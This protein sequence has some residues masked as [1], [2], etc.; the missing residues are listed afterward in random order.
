MARVG[1]APVVALEGVSIRRSGGGDPRRILRDVD[2]RVLAGERWGVLGPNGAGK[3][4]ML[5]VAAAHMPP[6]SGRATI[7][8]GRL[9]RV[10]M[11]ELR[12]RIGVVDPAL[13]GRFYPHQT[14]LEVVLTGTPGAIVLH[15][16]PA[17][18]EFARSRELLRLV[19]AESLA[20]RMFPTCSEGER[21]RVLLAR[22][23]MPEAPLLVLDE[24]AARLDLGGRVMFLAALEEAVRQRPGLATIV[25]SHHVEELPAS[26]THLLL[27]N[28]GAVVASGPI[29]EVA[30]DAAFS[31]CFEVAVRV[32]R[33]DSRIVVDA[34]RQP[35]SR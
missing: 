3:S 18:S 15:E 25:V 22:A 30:T 5:R 12:R 20:G 26:T 33:V 35:A 14:V 6:S 32:S 11:P 7:L 10:S 9:G 17:P 21:A 13:A 1:Q 29:D 16:Q 24:P 27:L 4:T 34:S 8:G 19:A 31:A 28:D 2:W 23:L